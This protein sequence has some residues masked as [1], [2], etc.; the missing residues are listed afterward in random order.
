TRRTVPQPVRHSLPYLTIGGASCSVMVRPCFGDAP[1]LGWCGQCVPPSHL[2][3]WELHPAIVP[4]YSCA[5]VL[6]R[7]VL[8]DCMYLLLFCSVN[9]YCPFGHTLMVHT[10]VHTYNQELMFFV[11]MFR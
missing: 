5:L 3:E 11:D 4:L 10:Q 6:L 7:A 2:L 9:P 1:S 8:G